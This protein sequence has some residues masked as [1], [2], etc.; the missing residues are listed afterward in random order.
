LA[1]IGFLLILTVFVVNTVMRYSKTPWWRDL[2]KVARSVQAFFFPPDEKQR[3]ARNASE[4]TALHVAVDADPVD[5]AR[6]AGSRPEQPRR[7]AHS[8]A[9]HAGTAA[10][11]AAQSGTSL[12]PEV[13]AAAKRR[14]SRHRLK[15]TPDA[16]ASRKETPD[17]RDE[18]RAAR[19]E[20]ASGSGPPEPDD[21]LTETR[22]IARLPV[23]GSR[24]ALPD[25]EA[26]EVLAR[27][28]VAGDPF[29]H[30]S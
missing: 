10:S 18:T 21:A 1:T 3:P 27:V 26:T 22:Q 8:S 6:H 20:P 30:R 11:P 12:S 28:E 24:H 5:P 23:Q 2:P 4:E 13:A 7:A 9:A 19:Q 15:E 14:R 25:P 17:S 16:R 29:G